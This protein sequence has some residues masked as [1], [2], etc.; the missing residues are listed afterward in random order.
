MG[1]QLEC[2]QCSAFGDFAKLLE[3]YEVKNIHSRKFKVY[4][5]ILKYQGAVTFINEAEGLQRGLNE[6]PRGNC[7]LENSPIMKMGVV[8]KWVVYK[9]MFS[10]V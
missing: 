1:L 6:K 8:K 2:L 5:P 3:L 9:A 4:D 10:T 7:N